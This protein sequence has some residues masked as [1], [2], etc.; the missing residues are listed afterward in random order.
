ML[1]I[2]CQPWDIMCFATHV[3]NQRLGYFLLEVVTDS[4]QQLWM[5]IFRVPRKV[6]QVAPCYT[7]FGA[8]R[9][10]IKNIAASESFRF[11]R[12]TSEQIEEGIL[13]PSVFT[14]MIYLPVCYLSYPII[15]SFLSGNPDSSAPKQCD[16]SRKRST[17]GLLLLAATASRR[18]PSPNV[19]F[20]LSR[21][22][23][24]KEFP[25][26]SLWSG[27]RYLI[28]GFQPTKAN[29]ISWNVEKFWA[30]MQVQDVHWIS[31]G[32]C[33]YLLRA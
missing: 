18:N 7:Y 5:T 24:S 21:S 15:P 30:D 27:N 4:E 23:S 16:Q 12:T 26:R 9:H 8:Q 32:R 11:T 25:K 10:Q 13:I 14:L 28:F 6:Q 2:K 19:R 3:V 22:S 20:F 31:V 29:Q 17:C 33:L 1:M